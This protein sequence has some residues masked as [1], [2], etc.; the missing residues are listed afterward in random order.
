MLWLHAILGI[1]ELWDALGVSVSL[2]FSGVYSHSPMAFIE[3]LIDAMIKLASSPPTWKIL[4][5]AVLV[6]FGLD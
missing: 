6:K 5:G 3:G 2:F 1:G 4:A